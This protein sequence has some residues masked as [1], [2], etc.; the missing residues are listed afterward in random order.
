MAARV[1]VHELKTWPEP[2]QAVWDRR[3]RFEVRQNDRS[4]AVGD[5]LV[6]RE[7]N[8]DYDY[9]GR[10]ILAEILHVECRTWGLP[11]RLAVLGIDIIDRQTWRKDHGRVSCRSSG[12]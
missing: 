9:T 12:P 3:K 6:L 7:W 1:T 2:F 11:A 8:P 10:V 4:F 5:L